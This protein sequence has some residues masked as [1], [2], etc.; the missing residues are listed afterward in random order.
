DVIWI[1]PL[2]GLTIAG[3]GAREW[4]LP[5][6][7]RGPLIT[8]AV[9]VSI[10]WPIVF[11]READFALWIM[12]LPRVSNTSIGIGPWEVNQNVAY[13]AI[14]H[15]L[16]ILWIDALCRWYRHDVARFRGEVLRGMLV[17]AGIAAAVSVYQGF[18]DLGFLNE[19]F[20]EY[21]I[22]ASGTLADPNKLGTVAAFWTIGA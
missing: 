7:W 18:V 14:G 5:A 21:M 20:W 4:S 1:L 3:G 15:L 19:G 9:I 22:R 8:W 17:A 12:P 10:A 16:G 2:L 13:F 6:R 11:L